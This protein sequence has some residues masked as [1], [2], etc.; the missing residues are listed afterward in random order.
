MNWYLFPKM[1]RNLSVSR[2]MEETARLELDGPTALVRDGYWI[3]ADNIAADLK[4]YIAEAKKLGLKVTYADTD[5]AVDRI[6]EFE[7]GIKALK[8]AGIK[9]FRL[10]FLNKNAAGNVRNTA[11]YLARHAEKTARLCGK[12]GIRAVLQIHGIFYPHCATAAYNAVKGLDSR[13]IGVKIDPGNNMAAEGHE[14]FWYQ[15]E[16]LGE[17]AAAVGLKDAAAFKTVGDDGSAVWRRDFV[18][19]YEGEADYPQLFKELKKNRFDGDLILMPF[20]GEHGD[21]QFDE[22]LKREIVYF[23]NAVK[24][25]Y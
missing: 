14:L 11:D 6:E 22:K 18:P 12:I 10:G 25:A 15:A 17:Y 23:K 8:D 7:S 21:G 19:A 20:Y 13:Y 4:A 5:F 3:T 24:S 1:Y 16:L 9:N 2:L